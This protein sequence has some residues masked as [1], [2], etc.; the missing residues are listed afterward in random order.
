MMLAYDIADPRRL[1]QV[2]RTARRCGMPLQ[3]NVFIDPGT[4]PAI[5]D[6]AGEL[7]A[8]IDRGQDDIRIYPLPIRQDLVHYGRQRLTDGVDLFG[9]S[10]IEQGFAHVAWVHVA[11]QR[12]PRQ[13]GDTVVAASFADAGPYQSPPCGWRLATPPPGCAT[14]KCRPPPP[15]YAL[16]GAGMLPRAHLE[17]LRHRRWLDAWAIMSTIGGGPRAMSLLDLCFELRNGS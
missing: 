5:D 10:P 17:R 1:T 16:G 8:I 13:R 7:D 4:A 12:V 11:P 2:H 3:Y 9:G 6:L 15:V 14:Y